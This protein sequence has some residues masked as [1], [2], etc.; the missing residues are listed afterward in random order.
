LA[1]LVLVFT[2]WARTPAR[3]FLSLTLAA[4]ALIGLGW[5]GA[6]YPSEAITTTSAALVALYLVT[7]LVVFPL[8]ARRSEPSPAAPSN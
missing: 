8:L 4:A 2:N 5:C 7:L 6:Q 1:P 3:A